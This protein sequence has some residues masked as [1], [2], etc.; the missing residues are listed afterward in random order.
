[1]FLIG[2]RPG[3]QEPRVHGHLDGSP[4]QTVRL[5]AG[6]DLN[7]QQSPHVVDGERVEL[8]AGG[9]RVGRPRMAVRLQRMLGL[10]QRRTELVDPRSSLRPSREGQRHLSVDE[11][12]PRALRLAER[13]L[14]APFALPAPR[15]SLDRCADMPFDLGAE[16]RQ[17]PERLPG[18]PRL[19]VEGRIDIRE[20]RPL[21]MW[22]KAEQPVV[23]YVDP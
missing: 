5:R 12:I 20:Q 10:D 1:M 4:P 3:A 15:S 21:V 14:I 7:R 23:A 9:R 16:V 8:V 17:R 22:R 6:L 18:R 11:G 19:V 2:F 13:G